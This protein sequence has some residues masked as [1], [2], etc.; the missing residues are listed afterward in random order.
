MIG[1]LVKLGSGAMGKLTGLSLPVCLLPAIALSVIGVQQIALMSSRT[2]LAQHK[3]MHAEHLAA[4]ATATA[5]AQAAARAAESANGAAMAAIDKQLT[6]EKARA[7]QTITALRADLDAGRV[8]LRS[9]FTC[10]TDDGLPTPGAASSAG[11][12]GSGLRSGDAQFLV[13]LADA[14]DARIR[15]TQAVI[16]ADRKASR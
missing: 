9:R 4:D 11:D 14:C 5:D 12:G 13:R 3:A 8:R 10:P 16:R 7:D 2:Q 6:E 15:A 1:S